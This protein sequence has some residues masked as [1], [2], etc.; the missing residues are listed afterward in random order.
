MRLRWIG[1]WPAGWRSCFVRHDDAFHGGL[2]DSQLVEDLDRTLKDDPLD[3]GSGPLI[4]GYPGDRYLAVTSRREDP[5]MRSRSLATRILDSVHCSEWR[6]A[7]C[8][9]LIEGRHGLF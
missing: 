7:F 9:S 3:A 1:P 8:R 2:Q 4:T 5:Q 6:L